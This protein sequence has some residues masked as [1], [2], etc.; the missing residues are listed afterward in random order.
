MKIEW[1]LSRALCKKL[2]KELFNDT[3][4]IWLKLEGQRWEIMAKRAQKSYAEE[5]EEW[6]PC[7]TLE[8]LFEAIQIKGWSVIIGMDNKN[9]DLNSLFWAKIDVPV[10]TGIPLFTSDAGSPVEAL[11]KCFL[12]TYEE[13]CEEE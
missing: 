8:E 10:L 7:P 6:Y 9:K 1:E 11:C 5:V 3:A 13:M 4:G 2:D 12:K